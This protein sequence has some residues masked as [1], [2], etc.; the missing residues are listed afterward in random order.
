MG[1]RLFRPKRLLTLALLAAAIAAATWWAGYVP[2]DPMAIYR[3]IP[4]TASLVGRHLVLPDRWGEWQGNPL[5]QA[6]IRTIG[7]DPAAAARLATDPESQRWFRK[8]AGREG[9]VAF[10]PGRVGGAPAWMAVSHLG[11]ESQKLRWQLILF[12]LPGFVRMKEFPGRSVWE[13]KARD[14]A[15]GQRLVIAF[16][17]GVIMAC[18]SENRMAIAEALA[19]YDGNLPRLIDAEPAFANFAGGDDR[20]VPDRFWIRDDSEFAAADFP[21]VV[22]EVPTFRADALALSAATAGLAMVPKER[23]SSVDPDGLARLL[24][25]APCVAAAVSRPALLALLTQLDLLPDVRH[26]LR[27]VLDVATAD[28]LV[29]VAMDGD[30][31]GRLAWGAIRKLGLAGFRVPTLLLA[32]PAPNAGETAA[33]IQRVLDA[34]NARYRGA[35]ILQ[36]VSVPPFTIYVLASAGGDEWVDDL[37]LANRPAYAILDGWLLAASNLAALQKLA[38]A[39]AE[40]RRAAHTPAWARDLAQPTAAAAWLDLERSQ[41]VAQSAVGYAKLAQ[42]AP[43]SGYTRA[44]RERLEEV[45]SWID[46]SSNLAGVAQGRLSRRDG[47]TVL[48]LE[49]GLSGA[50][51]AE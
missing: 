37:S 48:A 40:G 27:M 24:G 32:T 22:V 9:T 43:N 21:G 19:A 26:A 34:S 23:A 6:V 45:K 1:A 39:A 7:L 33:A 31:G 14:L 47:Q 12:R 42:L 11:G 18:L 30:M 36:P 15:P 44:D 17:E 2:Y 28:R 35:F 25:D 13:V 51:A 41:R 3:P 20:S 46:A 8:L 10:L 16:G 5:A 29:A 4:A 50:A 49:L 38:Q